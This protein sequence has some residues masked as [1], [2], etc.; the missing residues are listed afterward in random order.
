MA[1]PMS[2]TTE[3]PIRDPLRLAALRATGL[4][5]SPTEAPFDR[6]TSLAVTILRAPIALISLV[7]ED[8]QFFKSQVGLPSPW[9]ERR[10]TPLSHSFCKNVVAERKPLI[11]QDAREHPT[12]CRNG[13][14]ADLN[15]I[16][17]LGVPLTTPNGEVIGSFCVIDGRR[18]E[19]RDDDL[20]VLRDLSNCVMSEVKL[21]TE[22][23]EKKRAEQK[24]LEGEARLRGILDSSLDALITIDYRGVIVEFNPSAERIFGVSSAQALGQRLSDLII[25]PELREPHERGLQN[26][27]E[28]GKGPGLGRRIEIEALRANETRFPVELAISVVHVEGPP[29]FTASL[30]DISDRKNAENRLL[31]SERR[32]RSSFED[33]PIGMALVNLEGRWLSVNRS[34]CDILGHGESELLASDLQSITHPDDLAMDLGQMRRL[35]EGH[36]LSYRQEKRFLHKAGHEIWAIMAVSLI[37]DGQGRPLYFICQIEDITPRIRAEAELLKAHHELEQRVSDRTAELSTANRALQ[38]EITDRRRIEQELSVSNERFRMMTEASPQLVWS[39]DPHGRCDYLNP[40]FLKYTGVAQEHSLG[41]GWIELIHPDDQAI[42]ASCWA[43]AVEGRGQYDLEYRLRAAEG[44]Y[45]WF[46]IRGVPIRDES[47]RI[48]RFLGTCTDIDDRKRAEEKLRASEERLRM[49]TEAMPQIV[50]TATPEGICDYYNRQFYK[51]TGLLEDEPPGFGWNPIVH[52][53]DRK[54]VVTQWVDA[55][56]DKRPYDLEYRLLGAD[57][58]YRWFKVRAVSIRDEADQILQWVGTCTD[59]D[60]QKRAEE[61]LRQSET[62]LESRV[63][64]RTA[65]LEAASTALRVSAAEL[66]AAR[67]KALASTQAKAAFLANMSHEV[68]TPMVAVLGYADILLDSRL[69]KSDRDAALQGIRRNGSHL[70]QLINDILDL[71]KIEAGRMELD[72]IAYSPWQVVL[73]TASALGPRTSELSISL[74]LEAISPLPASALMDPIRVRQILMNLVSNALK[75]SRCGNQVVLRMGMRAG[76]GEKAWQLHLEVEDWGIG[77]SDVQ[78]NQLFV[79]FQ[80]ADSSTT[81][82]FGGTGLGLSIC[83]R[84]VE[85][86]DGTISVRSEPGRGS[87]FSVILPLTTIDPEEA[88]ICPADL[89]IRAADEPGIEGRLIHKTLTGSV[90]LVED[91]PD[92][93]RVLRYYLSQMGLHT[94]TAENG[95]IAV[96]VALAGRFDA[97]LMDMQLPEID[98]Y[99]A[100]SA[101]RRAGFE[102][103]II[104]LTAHAMAGDRERCLRA[105]CTD[106]LTKP[107]DVMTL[108]ETLAHHLAPTRDVIAS[109]GESPSGSRKEPDCEAILSKYADDPGLAELIREFVASLH[110]KVTNL[111]SLLAQQ[112]IGEVE[113]L[114]H[115]I[116]GVGGMYGYPCLTEMAALIEAAA[117]EN[118][119][120]ELIGELV[121]EFADLCSKIE[122]GLK[123]SATAIS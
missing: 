109:S 11:V 114:A 82:K 61:A 39:T 102:S 36:I 72:L 27:L 34:L 62:L 110:Q 123:A 88:W 92:N 117:K 43:N 25:P 19:W 85:I 94:E 76:P 104:A 41:F 71:S 1:A 13:A 108:Y 65:E 54:R 60:D 67:D 79:P 101:L 12:L 69:P 31:E 122:N 113:Q 59:I 53:D 57:G 51:Y 7:D 38:L 119:N 55:I 32:F 50:W 80:Q 115:R 15:V 83:R 26:Y 68:R 44:S 63:R 28:T 70:L 121:D 46:K 10:Q 84:L 42:S 45:R 77:M 99:G 49:L 23:A 78:I 52:P 48:V 106:Y 105:G 87:S 56:E 93:Q 20:Q 21:R 91:S 5:D 112:Q 81:R 86:M 58:I 2:I 97:V 29:L 111:R 116:K 64:E 33:A 40:A 47:G 14:V 118:Q 37:R 98:G 6:L 96:E 107:I 66:E 9:S 16:S 24:L 35:L 89:G 120:T 75:F 30:R 3:E 18:R 103:P 90:L 95:R 4:L 8:R 100:T 73:E 22:M 74:K 17:Y